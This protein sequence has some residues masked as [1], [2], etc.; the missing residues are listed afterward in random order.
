MM[1]FVTKIT[2]KVM[3]AVKVEDEKM[4]VRL[5]EDVK[6]A[7]K[8]TDVLEHKINIYLTQLSHGNLS[9]DAVAHVWSLFDVINSIERMGDCG[10]KI[11]R[12]L[13]KFHTKQAFSQA[14][15]DNI[16]EIA[17]LTKEITRET[18]KAIVFVQHPTGESAKEANEILAQAAARE[19][20]LNA[21]RKKLL[22]DR[23]TRYYEGEE[24]SPDFITAYS[25][26]LSNFE[27]IGD[28]ALRVTEN[29]L[30]ARSPEH[31]TKYITVPSKEKHA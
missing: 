25:D 29:I 16:E 7:E 27:R 11:A 5:V 1:S 10:E 14:D 6:E 17:K 28:Y 9:R 8:T 22:K 23:S 31:G 26:I 3:H 21:L 18:R 20:E 30:G 13:E 2:D 19:E 4:F 24:A 15:I 12:I